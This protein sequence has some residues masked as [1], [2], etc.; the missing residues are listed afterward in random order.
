[1]SPS[2]RC[3]LQSFSKFQW[4]IVNKTVCN[5]LKLLGIELTAIVIAKSSGVPFEN[6]RVFVI[7]WV[8]CLSWARARQR[9]QPEREFRPSVRC[10][11]VVRQ[12]GASIKFRIGARTVS[13]ESSQGDNG[14]AG[15][16]CLSSPV[17]SEFPFDVRVTSISV[18]SEQRQSWRQVTSSSRQKVRSQGSVWRQRKWRRST[19]S[20]VIVTSAYVIVTSSWRNRDVSISK[21]RF[22]LHKTW[23]LDFIPSGLGLL[24]I[25]SDTSVFLV[26]FG[27]SSV[28]IFKGT[29]EALPKF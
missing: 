17:T 13:T 26:V 4:F 15:D 1:M 27:L 19:S 25:K 12:R 3:Y 21:L 11:R 16:V 20:H 23:S 7:G 22:G 29:P 10:T 6:E 18:T 8:F 28:V 14:F 24:E 2:Y 9:A 5:C